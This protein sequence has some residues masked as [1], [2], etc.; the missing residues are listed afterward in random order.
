MFFIIAYSYFTPLE[1]R[2]IM[3]DGFE[4][5]KKAHRER[6]AGKYL[7]VLKWTEI[8]LL[9][10]QV[11]RQI[12]RKRKAS[13][14]K[15][16]TPGKGTQRLSPSNLWP[17]L[18][19]VSTGYLQSPRLRLS[20]NVSIVCIQQSSRSRDEK[21]THPS[22]GQNAIGAASDSRCA[23]RAAES[24]KIHAVAG[25]NEEFYPTEHH[26]HSRTRYNRYRYTD[27]RP[28]GGSLLEPL[29]FS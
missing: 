4:D 13:T 6:R 22:C 26:F 18:R 23:R 8:K 2:G 24:R 29:L 3:E 1:T 20:I 17:R 10:Q 21:A 5:K 11:V 12:R 9:F 27:S 14:S 15:N 19:N 16:S 28:A 7:F 25:S